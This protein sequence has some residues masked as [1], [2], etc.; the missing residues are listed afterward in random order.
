MS[1]PTTTSYAV[2]ALL[3]V[4]P[5]TTYELAKNMERS[6]RDVWPRLT[7]LLK[8]GRVPLQTV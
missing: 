1:E 8:V 6:L 3:A 7:G 4:Q 2:L 5:M